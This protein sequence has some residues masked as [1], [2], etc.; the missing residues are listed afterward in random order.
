[1]KKDERRVLVCGGRGYSD[2]QKVGRVL[3]EENAKCPIDLIITGGAPG[4]DTLASKWAEW[5]GFNQVIVPANWQ[6][7]GKAAGPI[8]NKLML[9][10][11]EPTVIIAFPGGVGTKNMIAQAQA[12]GLRVIEVKE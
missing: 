11:L 2:R 7:H 4:A 12:Q 8:R 3:G 5:Y 1:M 6:K 10:L 9:D